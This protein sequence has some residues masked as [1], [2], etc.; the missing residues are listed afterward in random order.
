MVTL[1][2]LEFRQMSKNVNDIDLNPQIKNM[3]S[4]TIAIFSKPN[5]SSI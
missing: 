1:Q 3:K 5:I 2:V 4:M